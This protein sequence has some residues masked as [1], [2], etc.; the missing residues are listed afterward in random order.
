MVI[1]HSHCKNKY[2]LHSHAIKHTKGSKLQEVVISQ[3][4]NYGGDHWIVNKLPRGGEG[5]LEL[6]EFESNLI[7]D[8]GILLQHKL[9]RKY[10]ASSPKFGVHETGVLQIYAVAEID[11]YCVWRLS[12]INS[13]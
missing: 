11:D 3:T 1:Q 9:T 12:E 5:E 7:N 6:I 13:T 8:E 4:N 10:L 2:Y